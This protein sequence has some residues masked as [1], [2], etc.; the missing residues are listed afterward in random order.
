ML[1]SLV[2]GWQV[3]LLSLLCVCMGVL[4]HM[5]FCIVT[6]QNTCWSRNCANALCK[7]NFPMQNECQQANKFMKIIANLSF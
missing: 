7:V 1:T 3:V 4:L 2:I 5:L 6:G